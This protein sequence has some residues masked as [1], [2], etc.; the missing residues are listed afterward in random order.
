MKLEMNSF[1]CQKKKMVAQDE[2]LSPV[3][4]FDILSSA[5]VHS[6]E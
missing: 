1:A 6:S 2:S 3:P 5:A 4:L